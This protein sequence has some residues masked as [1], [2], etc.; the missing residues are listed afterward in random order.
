MFAKK[1]TTVNSCINF[2][3]GSQEEVKNVVNVERI[4]DNKVIHVTK[5]IKEKAPEIVKKV[6][7]KEQC[8]CELCTC[9]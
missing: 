1:Q 7:L 4:S 9:G 6:P 3:L 5:T 8:I 2:F